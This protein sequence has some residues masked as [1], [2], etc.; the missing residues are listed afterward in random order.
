MNQRDQRSAC[1]TFLLTLMMGA[2]ASVATAEVLFV[3][4]LDDSNTATVCEASVANDCSLRGAII[5]ANGNGEDDTIWISR[6]GT[7]TLSL[8]GAGDARGDLD[9]TDNLVINGRDRRTAVIEASGIP[10]GHRVFE[11]HPGAEVT[12]RDVSITDSIPQYVIYQGAGIRNSGTLTL[13]RVW[14]SRIATTN[15]GGGIYNTSTGWLELYRSTIKLNSSQQTGGGIYNQG[16]LRLFDSTIYINTAFDDGGGVFNEADGDVLVVRSTLLSNISSSGRG[17]GAYNEGWINA[18]NSSFAGNDAI[19][20]FG[21][22]VYNAGDLDLTNVTFSRNQSISG[23]AVYNALGCQVDMVNTIVDGSCSTEFAFITSWGG[24]LESP[25]T[26]CNLDQAS[27]QYVTYDLFPTGGG[28]N[29]GYTLSHPISPGHP[30]IDAG[31]DNLCPDE[32]QRGH[33]RP[34]DGDGDLDDGCDSG[35]FE[36]NPEEIFLDG[37]ERESTYSWSEEVP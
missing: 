11:V 37:F 19:D 15:R 29:G 1:T 8:D 4:R 31:I 21:G 33:P 36:Y 22:G 5:R 7:F 32:D 35:S 27:D 12:I 18:V 3:D 30:A 2:A 34:I 17:G 24:N 28:F 6:D 10:G 13:E 16:V 23:T 25:G 14:I 26:T 20:A 9:I